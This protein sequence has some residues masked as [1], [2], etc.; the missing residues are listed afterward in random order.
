MSDD[1]PAP[2]EISLEVFI[3]PQQA[4]GVWA[5]FARVNHSEHEFTIDFVRIDYATAPKLTGVI[6]ARVGVSPLF[7]TQLITALQDNWDK[8]AKKAM[9]REVYGDDEPG[10]SEE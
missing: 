8:Y 7:V 4:G 6:V 10:G 3:D 2:E 9:P 1:A 5:N